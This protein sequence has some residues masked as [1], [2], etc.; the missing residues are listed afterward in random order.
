M[1]VTLVDR[2]L[3][4]Q[5]QIG[6]CKTCYNNTI[7]TKHMTAEEYSVSTLFFLQKDGVNMIKLGANICLWS[8]KGIGKCQIRGSIPEKLPTTFKY[9]S[10]P[11]PLIECVVCWTWLFKAWCTAMLQLAILKVFVWNLVQISIDETMVV[12]IWLVLHPNM[13]ASG[14]YT[15]FRAVVQ[16]RHNINQPSSRV[17]QQFVK[18]NLLIKSL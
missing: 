15:A 10:A 7:W 8:D 13:A 1:T 5:G 9:G 16:N 2:W 3:I 14:H 12:N 6:H 18:T 11:P 17:F 4:L